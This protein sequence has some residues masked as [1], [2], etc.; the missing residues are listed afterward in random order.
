MSEDTCSTTIKFIAF[1][2]SFLPLT[3]ETPVRIY[4]Y[5]LWFL[6]GMQILLFPYCRCCCYCKLCHFIL[7]CEFRQMGK[8]KVFSSLFNENITLS[9]SF[10]R[11]STPGQHKQDFYLFVLTWSADCEIVVGIYWP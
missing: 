3:K 2:T 1:N 8:K 11:L 7:I 6:C 4:I 10:E 9:S 5:I